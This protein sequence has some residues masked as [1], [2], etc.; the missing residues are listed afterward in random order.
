MSW[1]SVP[2]AFAEV[3]AAHPEQLAI[4][5]HGRPALTYGEL[6]SQAAGFAA[7]L[8]ERGVGPDDVVGIALGRRP[9]HVVALL[10]TWMARAVTLPLAADAPAARRAGVLQEA[11]PALVLTAPPPAR[12]GAPP[13]R[14]PSPGERA[15]IIYTSGSSGAP[16]GVEVNHAGL[17]PMLEAQIAAFGLRPGA[18]GLCALSLTFDASLSDIG[19]ALLSGATLCLEAPASLG[20]GLMA[21]LADRGITHMDVPPALLPVLDPEAL[22][23]CVE[24]IIIGG[25][26]CDPAVVR[27]WARRATVINVYGP[28]EATV[29]THLTRCDP[30][31][32]RRP[33][34]GAPLPGVRASV[35][36][37]TGRPLPPGEPGELWLGGACLARGYIG[38]PDLEA[39]RFV[40]RG[41]AR[42]YR[43]G[44]R[45]VED[46][47]G[48]LEFLGRVDRQLKLR[49]HLIAPEEIE[50]ALITTPGVARAAALARPLSP[51][52]RGV[53]LLDHR[54]VDD[55]RHDSVGDATVEHLLEDDDAVA[56]PAAAGVVGHVLYTR[57]ASLE[58]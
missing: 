30:G 32:W 52:A 23:G 3:A 36:D 49:G 37:P 19:C 12:E 54:R 11:R 46:A 40:E 17:T 34:I 18:R 24:T 48:R 55:G 7:W 43:T 39:A 4:L 27:R 10:G 2:E 16:K 50:A 47:E 1:R 45:V 58:H 57:K 51:D 26:P 33:W 38:R 8:G 22:P 31:T 13:A 28:T 35:H 25:E 21:T 29:C 15:Y 41:G 6:L 9:E 20:P 14:W 44:D 53:G 5:D 42:S 56:G